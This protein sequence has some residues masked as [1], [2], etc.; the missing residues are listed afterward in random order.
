[1]QSLAQKQVFSGRND[2]SGLEEAF[3]ALIIEEDS[4]IHLPLV[5]LQNQEHL[6]MRKQIT[7][8]ISR[9]I[10]CRKIYQSCRNFRQQR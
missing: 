5:P 4:E 6:P 1:M 8:T 9:S 7:K 2:F 3:E 10:I